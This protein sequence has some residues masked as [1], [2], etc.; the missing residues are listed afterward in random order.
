MQHGKRRATCVCSAYT[1]LAE[2]GNILS[3]HV[4]RKG[5]SFRASNDCMPWSDLNSTTFVSDFDADNW[6]DTHK[7][8]STT[9][10]ERRRPG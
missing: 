5:M 1:H 7:V 6:M 3:T 10:Y 2:I 8:K 9:V 4:D